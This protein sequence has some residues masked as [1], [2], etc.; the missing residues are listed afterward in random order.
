MPKDS[1]TF[2][3]GAINCT[4]IADGRNQPEIE[5]MP[6]RFPTVPRQ[7]LI[8]ALR[9]HHPNTNRISWSMN[10]LLIQN[11]DR[12][13]LVDTGVG[14]RDQGWGGHLHE[15]LLALVEPEA[16]DTVVL[17]HGHPDHIGGLVGPDGQLVYPNAEY[18]MWEAEWQYWMG[19][20]GYVH[21]DESW[22]KYFRPTLEPIRA[23]LKLISAEDQL[24]P[25]VQALAAPGHTP[26]HM[27]LLLESQGERLFDLVDALHIEVQ[28]SHPEWSPVFDVNPKMAAQTRAS[29]LARAADEGLLTLLYHFGFP[30][31]GH[32]QRVEGG[33]TWQPWQKSD[34]SPD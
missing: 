25:G 20:D 32:V 12:L 5:S 1:F 18:I 19:S 13:V 23:R 16:I 21:K 11:A 2:N 10:C 8:A 26:G 27:G 30:G 34:N 3:V 14:W 15:R 9:A 31:L 17:T 6:E 33:F 7:A 24:A 28:T 22:A 29:L 4:I